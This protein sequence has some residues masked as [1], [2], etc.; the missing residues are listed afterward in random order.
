[1][2]QPQDPNS[3]SGYTP[4]PQGL[5]KTYV[6]GDNQQQPQRQPV[7]PDLQ[8][9][10]RANA[11]AFPSVNP[12]T[13][14]GGSQTRAGQGGIRYGADALPSG[15]EPIPLGSGTIVGLL[16]TGGMAKVYKIWNEKLEV[17]R[18]VKI[19]LP[20]QQ[21]DLKSRFETE[22][23]ITAKL[24]HPNIVEI[25]SVGDWNSLPYLEMEYIDGVSLESLISK[26]GKLPNAVCSSI[27]ILIARAL[28]YAHSQEFLI[29][30]KTYHGV[31]HRD[32]KPANI[33]IPNIGDVRLMDF[34]IARPTEASL[35]TVEGN[36]VGTMQYLSPEQ[37]DGVDIDNRTDIYSF[38]AI[39][40][41]I[42]TGTKTFP[43]D[44]ITNLMKKKIMNEYRKFSDFNF[45]VS[46]HL[47]RISQKCLQINKSDRY[48]DMTTLLEDLKV[49]HRSLT[50]DS[51]AKVLKK[52]IA[53]PVAFEDDF[54]G[55][56]SLRIS[57]KIVIPVAGLLGIG[58]LVAVFIITGPESEPA[59]G[60]DQPVATSTGTQSQQTKPLTPA[61]LSGSGNSLTPLGPSDKEPEPEPKP[62][63]SEPVKPP[64][65][66]KPV[67]SYVAPTR[68]KVPPKPVVEPEPVLSPADELKKRYI[69]EDFFAI[70]KKAMAER[71]YSD[72]ILAFENVPQGSNSKEK[73]LYLFDAYLS[74]GKI[75]DALFI[76]NN[77]NIMDAQFDYLCGRLYERTGKDKR[78]LEYYQSALTKPSIIRSRSEIRN[79]ALYQTAILWSA[80]HKT[81]PTADSRVQALNAWNTV[82]R[83][84]MGSPNH[85]RFKRANTELAT[86]Q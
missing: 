29:Y 14:T 31:I 16:G 7:F 62:V 33:M 65:P 30:G 49:A 78:A 70:G 26:H 35:H 84:Y 44:T 4:Q 2:N 54:K 19:L 12:Y 52:Y 10:T 6:E 38:G 50:A 85:P 72:A 1:M 61:T 34:G 20:T 51:P 23:K 17:F 60:G 42:L 83:T 28:E 47:A 8:P 22:A 27:A 3:R 86:I 46:P 68:P 75:K 24:H 58:A 66:H 15:N 55:K 39:L 80:Q 76:A 21:A 40:Y 67:A 82:K 41:E 45:N 53:D 13:Q 43:Q 73:T 81:N 18:A 37:M 5:D 9:G 32:L 36:I 69:L 63:V 64:K 71:A 48:P 56:I 11:T 79:D 57:P 77:E 59:G 25:Y 74:S